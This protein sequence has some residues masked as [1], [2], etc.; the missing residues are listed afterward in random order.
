[1]TWKTL[2]HTWSENS[3]RE[4][5]SHL[6]HLE[7]NS[8]IISMHSLLTVHTTHSWYTKLNFIPWPFK[9]TIFIYANTN[10]KE[11]LG[12]LIIVASVVDWENSR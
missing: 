9:L 2:V 4:V 1:M 6:S 12:D 8:K 11:G 10:G 5:S 7:K 3:A